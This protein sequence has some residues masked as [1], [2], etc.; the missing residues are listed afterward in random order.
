MLYWLTISAFM[1]E[2]TAGNAAAT[3]CCCAGSLQI[4]GVITHG[5]SVV[6]RGRRFNHY[7]KEII[8]FIGREMGRR[9][10]RN[11]DVV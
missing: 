5:L 2:T 4:K 1:P 3:S 8:W 7:F 6:I 10:D 11:A 9:G